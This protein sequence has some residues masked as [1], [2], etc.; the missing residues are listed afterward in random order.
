MNREFAIPETAF[1]LHLFEENT[2]LKSLNGYALAKA[3]DKEAA[4]TLIGENVI[5]WLLTIK[6]QLPNNTTYIAPFAKEATGDNAIPQVLADACAMVSGGQVDTNIV[7]VTRVFH[8]GADPMER[9]STR[10]TFEGEVAKGQPRRISQLH[11]ARRWY[12]FRCIGD[13]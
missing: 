6:Q 12:H 2:D 4:L 5:P 9:L 1:I 13:C 8:T 3:G 10:P 7:Q 11:F